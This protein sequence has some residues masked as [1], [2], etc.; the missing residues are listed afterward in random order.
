MRKFH[1]GGTSA[2][3]TSFPPSIMGKTHVIR[4]GIGNGKGQEQ[5]QDKDKEQEDMDQPQG[6][7]NEQPM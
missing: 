3:C 6:D 7:E 5:G 1:R 4:I 2:P